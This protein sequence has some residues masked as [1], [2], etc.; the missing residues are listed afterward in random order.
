MMALLAARQEYFPHV[1]MEGWR[2]ED[3]PVAF[4]SK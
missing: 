1:R 2:A 4:T 3:K